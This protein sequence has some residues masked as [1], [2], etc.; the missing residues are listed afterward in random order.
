MQFSGIEYFTF[1]VQPSLPTIS[2]IFLFFK[3][4]G[5]CPL[6]TNAPFPIPLVSSNYHSIFCLYEILCV[7]NVL[8]LFHSVLGQSLWSLLPVHFITLLYLYETPII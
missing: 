2:R 3:T 5:L 8:H 1:I 6:N 7:F 4:E